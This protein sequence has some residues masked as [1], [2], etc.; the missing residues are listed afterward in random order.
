MTSAQS[1]TSMDSKPTVSGGF[2]LIGILDNFLDEYADIHHDALQETIDA[3]TLHLKKSLQAHPDWADLADNA[4]V[5]ATDYGL[6]YR[7]SGDQTTSNLLEYGDPIQ[8]IHPTGM[9]RGTAFQR[10][11]S[12]SRDFN[13]RVRRMMETE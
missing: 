11:Q 3:E 12:V 8:Q 2:A 4:V 9:L 1:Y 6:E 5:T 13:N 7:V 10:N